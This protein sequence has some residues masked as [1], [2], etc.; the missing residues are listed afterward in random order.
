MSKKLPFAE[1]WQL[2]LDIPEGKVSTYKAVA[3]KLKLKNPRNVG[4]ML[5]QNED[6][7][8]IPCHRIIQSSGMI[9]GYAGE[10]LG[11]NVKKKL[12]L[13]KKEG[14]VFNNKGKIEDSSRVLHKL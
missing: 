7:P 3:T 8:E 12:K 10:A 5:K 2:L 11:E 13:L 9:G 4:Y 6:A 1:L 14:V